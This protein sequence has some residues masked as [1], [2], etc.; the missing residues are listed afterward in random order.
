[1]SVRLNLTARPREVQ[2]CGG[3]KRLIHD[4]WATRLVSRIRSFLVL[5][6]LIAVILGSSAAL[7]SSYRY[8]RI[9]AKA[10]STATPSP[11]TAMMAE[12]KILTMPFARCAPKPM[13]GGFLMCWPFKSTN[14]PE[15]S[16]SVTAD[17]CQ[18]PSGRA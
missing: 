2:F 17:A 8:F 14:F 13:G 9:G 4:E 6:P 10:D 18:D 5:A 1:M 16:A 12:A 7:A 11:G 3:L 15:T